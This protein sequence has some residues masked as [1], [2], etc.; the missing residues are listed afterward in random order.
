[1]CISD[2]QAMQQLQLLNAQR[3]IQLHANLHE[4]STNDD[5]SEKLQGKYHRGDRHCQLCSA[6]IVGA[7]YG[8]HLLRL[9][10][11]ALSCT[12]Q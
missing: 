4:L 7:I 10:A 2:G 5:N 1:M 9:M 12:T 6:Y 3:P 11:P 8:M